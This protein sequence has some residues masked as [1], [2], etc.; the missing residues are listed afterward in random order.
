MNERIPVPKH[1]IAG[2]SKE[3]LRKLGER[4]KQHGPGSF[5]GPHEILGIIT[6]EY[7]ELIDA[8]R[9]NDYGQVEKE[10]VDI[11]V[12]CLFGVASLRAAGMRR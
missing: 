3:I 2:V 8:V 10:L 9:D 5:I 12:G 11:A 1:I 4:L 7:D 6:E